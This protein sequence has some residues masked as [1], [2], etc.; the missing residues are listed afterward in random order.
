VAGV[1][2]RRAHRARTEPQLQLVWPLWVRFL[3][4]LKRGGGRLAH[5]LPRLDQLDLDERLAS[6]G[7]TFGL[8]QV[9]HLVRG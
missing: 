8:G 3:S 2:M 7:L 1:E 6:L 9:L 5:H 4:V